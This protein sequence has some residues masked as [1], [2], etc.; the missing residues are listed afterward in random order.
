MFQE[1]RNWSLLCSARQIKTLPKESKQC[2]W[3]HI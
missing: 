1:V 2:T 3:V